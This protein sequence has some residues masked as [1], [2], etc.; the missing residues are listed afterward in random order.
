LS[1]DVISPYDRIFI[2]EEPL[3][4]P[5]ELKQQGSPARRPTAGQDSA[6]TLRELYATGP[7][8]TAAAWCVV[9]HWPTWATGVTCRKD[10]SR[11][12]MDPE[13]DDGRRSFEF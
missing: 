10:S 6:R 13:I 12:D 8:P 3:S 5:A 1:H 9:A 11:V 4:A 2:F 7:L